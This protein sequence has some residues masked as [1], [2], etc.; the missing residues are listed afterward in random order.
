MAKSRR[1]KGEGSVFKDKQG[2]WNAQLLLGYSEK[3]GK[4]VF[5][6]FRSKKQ[7]VVIEKMNQYKLS[8]GKINPNGIENVTLE[9][10]LNAY[11][12]LKKGT[13]RETSYNSLIVTRNLIISRI[14]HLDISDVNAEIIQ[15]DLIADLSQSHAY[16]TVHKAY[17]LLNECMKYALGKDYILKNP[18]ISVKLPSKENFKSKEI[19]CLNDGEIKRFKKAATS[20]KATMKMPKYQYGNIMCLIIYTGLRVSELCALKWEDVDLQGRKLTVAKSIAVVYRNGKR[21]LIV[22]NTTKSG[23]TRI[24]PLNDKAVEILSKQAMLVGNRTDAYIVNGKTDIAD[25]TVVANSYRAI[26]KSAEITDGSGIHTLRHTFA[27]LAIRR[28][29]DIKVV[30]EILGHAS[31]SFTYNTYVHVIEEQ[32]IDAVN[33]LNNI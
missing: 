17:V 8:T 23:K 4:P 28:G 30:S 3:N 24:V 32:K 12:D 21:T 26:C 18:C 16:S 11:L 10:L 9:T 2:Y 27:S 7:S 13:I 22:Q 1:A 14:G 29:V 25:K 5:K 19:H 15:K 33:L 20:E 6:K 31:T